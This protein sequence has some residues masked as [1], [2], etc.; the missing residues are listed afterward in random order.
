MFFIFNK[1]S[2]SQKLVR[3]NIMKLIIV[4]ID[5]LSFSNSFEGVHGVVK[6]YFILFLFI[7]LF[8]PPAS[9]AS[10]RSELV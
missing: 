8:Y 5:A 2:K 4:F 9:E 1:F 10:E 6:F 7:I 3:G